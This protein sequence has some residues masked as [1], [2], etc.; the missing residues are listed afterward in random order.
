MFME[1]EIKK[2]IKKAKSYLPQLDS[3]HN[4]AHVGG[5]VEFALEI[6]QHYPQID[7]KVIEVAAWWHDAGR[8]IQEEHEQLSAEMAYRDL[9]NRGFDQ[10]FCRKVYEAIVLHGC[11]MNPQTLEGEI[12]RDADKLD[13]FGVERWESCLKADNFKYL[14]LFARRVEGQKERLHL[15]VS[16]KIFRRVIQEL[17]QFLKTIERE[18]H[19]FLEIKKKIIN[20][21]PI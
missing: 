6:V 1:Q 3:A 15:A 12:V 21:P 14:K 8:S 20:F 13:Y 5:V 9:K 19:Q 17:I 7:K 4:L 18:D 16:K 10:K 2:S 11:S